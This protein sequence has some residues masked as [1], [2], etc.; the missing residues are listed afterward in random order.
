MNRPSEATAKVA[1]QQETANRTSHPLPRLKSLLH[2]FVSS[3]TSYVT[4]Y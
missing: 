1:A 3:T 4:F 2:L